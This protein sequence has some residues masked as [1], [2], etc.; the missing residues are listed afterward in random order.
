[1]DA[2]VARCDLE[3]MRREVG[4]LEAGLTECEG[5]LVGDPS[6][7]HQRERDRAR[8]ELE[9][10]QLRA[11]QQAAAAEA[12]ERLAW[13]AQVDEADER[14]GP[15]RDEYAAVHDEV[16]ATLEAHQQALARLGELK[17]AFRGVNREKL[18]LGAAADHDLPV[19]GRE[20][21]YGRQVGKLARVYASATRPLAVGL[22]TVARG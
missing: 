13:Q 11:V 6:P 21:E 16:W 8:S 19:R 17:D 14:A 12:A 10:A 9:L 2:G 1:L 18:K 3:A 15:L 4:L 22:M 7:L 20:G 5:R